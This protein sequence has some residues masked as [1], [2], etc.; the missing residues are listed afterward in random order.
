[1]K[2]SLASLQTEAKATGFRPEILEKVIRLLSLLQAFRSHLLLRECLALKG[3]TALNL[4]VLDVPRLSVDLDFNYIGAVER[5]AML[6]ERP[7]VEQAIQAV[8]ASE[9]Y[10]IQRQPKQHAGGKWLLRY[11]SALGRQASLEI[12]LN[13]MY[14][15]PLWPI[16]AQDSRQV[17]SHK[18]E[19]VPVLDLHELAAGKLA[20]LLSRRASRDLFDTHQLLTKRKFDLGRLRTAFVLYGAMD[21]TRDWRTVSPADVAFNPR[22]LKNRLLPTLP[23]DYAASIGDPDTW[24]KRLIEECRS[25]LGAV[26][27]FTPSETEFLSRLLDKGEIAPSLLT[28]DSTL[29]QAIT[30]HPALRWRA[31]THSR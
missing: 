3:G 1:M 11:G 12:D 24:A 23:S 17:G 29:A 9:G 5:D 13:F 25:A 16:M 10:A 31:A 20:A 19:G 21:N 18:V 2:L 6:A 14:R 26:L 15:V 27:P 22:D 8:C 7:R 4:F 30:H 28:A